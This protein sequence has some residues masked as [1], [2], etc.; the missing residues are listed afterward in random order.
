[1]V[2]CFFFKQKTAYEIRISDWSSDVCSSDLGCAGNP[3]EEGDERLALRVGGLVIA[4]HRP[5]QPA[6]PRGKARAQS[7]RQHS[8]RSFDNRH[9]GY[10]ILASRANAACSLAMPGLTILWCHIRPAVR[11]RYHCYRSGPARFASDG[12]DKKMP[13]AGGNR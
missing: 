3:D 7:A 5:G 13:P 6:R 12:P 1:M 8:L 11:M 2:L 10:A 4:D 9:H